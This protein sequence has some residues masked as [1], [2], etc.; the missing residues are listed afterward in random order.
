MLSSDD[1]IPQPHNFEDLHQRCIVLHA[2]IDK[3]L[4]A[5]LGYVD[6]PRS[7][8]QTFQT[9]F[10]T[11]VQGSGSAEYLNP[12]FLDPTDRHESWIVQLII[13]DTI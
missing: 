5:I 13:Y 7:S 10:G 9:R 4:I 3:E 1:R 8:S 12:K 6:W 2:T 11:G